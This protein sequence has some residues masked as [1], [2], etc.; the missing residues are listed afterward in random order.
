MRDGE[1]DD[2]RAE[3]V[4]AR[5]IVPFVYRQLALM[6]QLGKRFKPVTREPL[7]T[8]MRHH[9]RKAAAELVTARLQ[10]SESDPHI[11]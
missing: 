8:A 10:S 9:C 5:Q 7:Q 1:T 6:I 11:S 4:I 2:M 3:L